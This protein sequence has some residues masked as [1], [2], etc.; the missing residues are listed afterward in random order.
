MVPNEEH[1]TNGDGASSST[2]NPEDASEHDTEPSDMAPRLMPNIPPPEDIR[3]SKRVTTRQNGDESFEMKQMKE[4]EVPVLEKGYD[5]T[6]YRQ[7]DGDG[8]QE[9]D[10]GCCCVC[11]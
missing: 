9:E 2:R 4:D 11:F 8:L 3:E 10:Q 5:V 1:P 7:E 6:P